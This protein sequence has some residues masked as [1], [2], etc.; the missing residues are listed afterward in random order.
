VFKSSLIY[1]LAFA[2][3]GLLGAFA[4]SVYTHQLT[5]AEY[6]VYSVGASVSFLI[7]NVVFGWI[8][9]SIGRFQAENP[10]QNYIPLAILSYF[11]SSLTL[12]PIAVIGMTSASPFSLF[13]VLSCLGLTL[14]QALFDIVQEIRRARH[15]SVRFSRASVLRSV[16]S[17][18]LSV[19]AAAYFRSGAAVLLVTA[20]SFLSLGIWTYLDPQNYRLREPFDRTFILRFLRYG[21]PLALSGFVFAGNSAFARSIVGWEL[22]ASAAGQFGAALDITG[23]ITAVL[24]GSICSALGPTAIAA[25]RKFGVVGA[26]RELMIG[27]E[28]FLGVLI[29]MVAGLIITAHPFADFVSGHAFEVAV[30]DLL[31]VL[32]VSRGLNVFAQFYLHLGF[33]IAERPLRQVV[34]GSTTLTVNIVCNTLLTSIYGLPG[35]AWALVIADVVGVIVSIVLPRPVLP[36]PLPFLKIVRIVACTLIMTVCCVALQS[37]LQGRA[38]EQFFLIAF[39]GMAIYAG[40]GYAADISGVRTQS[41]L[42]RRTILLRFKR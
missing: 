18:L 23:Q 26:R 7:G 32:A 27:V 13:A 16:V 41:E 31:P 36:M 20:I 12:I 3:P 4:F 9:F 10:E 2:L 1:F 40:C 11:A 17:F 21:M 8:R 25:Y 24:A 15:Q 5:P 14:A 28:F 19:A 6:A 38:S 37:S 30:G 29:P 39:V 34:C 22:G 35:A 42:W 33:Q